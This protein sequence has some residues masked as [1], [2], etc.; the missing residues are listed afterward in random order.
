MLQTTRVKWLG[1][2]WD[3]RTSEKGEA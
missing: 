1:V 3:Y 2:P